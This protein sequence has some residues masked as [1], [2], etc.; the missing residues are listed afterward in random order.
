MTEQTVP[1]AGVVVSPDTE[2][3]RFAVTMTGGVSLAVWMGGVARELNLLL[4]A[5]RAR[6]AGTASTRGSADTAAGPRPMPDDAL[7]GRYRGLLDLLDVL[8]DVDVLS[9]TSAGGINAV[10]LAYA[11]A[12]DRDLAPLRELWLELGALTDLLRDPGDPGITS[13]LYGD[14][15]L[16]RA[17]DDG[18]PALPRYGS[19]PAEAPPTQLLVTAT[20][21]GGEPV[22]L[23]DALNTRVGTVEHRGRFRFD[24]QDLTS[25]GIEHALAL[26]ARSTASFPGAFEPSFLPTDAVV[27]A[28][29]DSPGR[30]AMTPYSLLTRPHWAADGGLL[31]NQPLDLILEKVFKRPAEHHVRRALLFIVPTAAPAELVT[32][33]PSDPPGLLGALLADLRAATSQSISRELHAVAA[34]GDSVASTTELRTTLVDLAHRLGAE[35]LLTA[36]LADRARA[37]VSEQDARRSARAVANQVARAAAPRPDWWD[38]G[39]F[40]DGADPRLARSICAQLVAVRPE[41]PTDH[42]GYACW[43]PTVYDTAHA[44]V[45]DLLRRAYRHAVERDAADRSSREF[46]VDLIGACHA[47]RPGRDHDSP[48]TTAGAVLADPVD[49]GSIECTAHAVAQ[50]WMEPG[51]LGVYAAA[52]DRLATLLTDAQPDLRTLAASG[53]V[54]RELTM[55]VDHIGGHGP[56]LAAQRLFDLAATERALGGDQ[57]PQPLELIQISADTRSALTTRR[58]AAEKLC[59]LQLDHFG[60]FVKRS[61]RAN[62]WMWGR[63]D[64]AGWLV[65]AL[66]DPRRIAVVAATHAPA[67]GRLDWFTAQLERLTSRRPGPEVRD[68]LGFLD[69]PVAQPAALPVTAIWLAETWQE[70]IGVAELPTVAD[71]VLDHGE[72]SSEAACDWAGRAAHLDPQDRSSTRRLLDE[73]PIPTEKIADLHGSLRRELVTKALATTTAAIAEVPGLPVGLRPFTGALHATTHAIYTLLGRGN[74]GG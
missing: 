63:L 25:P 4:Q 26:A 11:R 33:D 64:G 44:L 17:L 1:A 16:F 54:N 67:G 14:R 65:H 8:V 60:A 22:E 49:R 71:A 5:S 24:E 39:A 29:D 43:G 10:L 35:R 41:L 30:P 7:R 2:Q 13:L 57:I 32:E 55:V 72:P 58:T 20:L 36:E 46:V 42:D 6:G 48:E 74:H 3:V 37:A 21:L 18:L 45:I 56:V 28:T 15:R 66:L 69:E 12:Q 53:P 38:D 19:P 31:D 51:A 40:A 59:G 27:P 73:S 61:W 50:A 9:G 52:W 62:D 34:H 70:L 68:E 47:A 23:R